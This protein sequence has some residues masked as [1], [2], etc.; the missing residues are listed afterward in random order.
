[1]A[2]PE[3]QPE[4]EDSQVSFPVLLTSLYWLHTLAS[5]QERHFVT[6]RDMGTVSPSRALGVM[7]VPWSIR[8]GILAVPGAVSPPQSRSTEQDSW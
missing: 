8:A 7:D 6:H 5:A 1:M 4:G 2:N 3:F